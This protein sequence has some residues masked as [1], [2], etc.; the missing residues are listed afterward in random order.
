MQS[1]TP[2]ADPGTSEGIYVFTR[3]APTVAVG[4]SVTV[5]GTVSE[6]RPGGASG[7]DNTTTTEI[8]SPTVK[9]IASGAPRCPRR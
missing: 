2:D 5:S 8:V 3:T 7:N 9:T 1:A 4:D 6:F